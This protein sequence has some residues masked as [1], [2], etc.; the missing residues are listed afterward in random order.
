MQEIAEI[1]T[2]FLLLLNDDRDAYL[3]TR[4]NKEERNSKAQSLHGRS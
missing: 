2:S 4:T 3:M 1:I